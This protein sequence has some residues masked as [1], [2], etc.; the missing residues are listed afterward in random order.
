MSQLHSLRIPKASEIVASAIHS[1][2]VSEQLAVGV[3]MPSEPELMEQF[4]VGRATVREA[5]RLLEHDGLID[6]RRGVNGG[7]FVRH[8]DIKQIS[9][10]MSLLFGTKKATLRE[11]LE[12]RMLIEPAAAKMAADNST[13]EDLGMMEPVAAVGNKLEHVPDLHMLIANASGNRVL[14][15]MLNALHHSFGAHFRRN[16]IRDDQL[17]ET[18]AAHKKIARQIVKRNSDGAAKA[19]QIHL[20]AYGQYLKENN[21]LDAPIVPRLDNY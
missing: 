19:M 5:L 13:P 16:H 11:F 18:Q 12:F 14:S 8:P 2:I 20:E 7:N 3:R 9:K 6:I 21:L 4:G 17:L 10:T 1:R 15:V